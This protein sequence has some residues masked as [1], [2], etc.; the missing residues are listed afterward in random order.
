MTDIIQLSETVQLGDKT[1]TAVI[2]YNDKVLDQVAAIQAQSVAP[3][4]VWIIC[5]TEDEKAAI[6]EPPKNAEIWVGD[7]RRI[8]PQSDYLWIV[9]KAV[10]P[11]NRYLELVLKLSLTTT[12]RDVLLGSH[13][14][15]LKDGSC[16]PINKHQPVDVTHHTWFLRREWLPALNEKNSNIPLGYWISSNLKA[17]AGIRSMVLPE[18]ENADYI[19]QGPKNAC[20]DVEEYLAKA[21]TTSYKTDVVIQKPVEDKE[22]QAVMLL[23]DEEQI[24]T[25]WLQLA[26]EMHKRG[27]NNAIV[28]IATTGRGGLDATDIVT[29]LTNHDAKCGSSLPKHQVHNLQ[30]AG[31]SQLA[32]RVTRLLMAADVKVLIH[33]QQYGLDALQ[34]V[35]HLLP[36]MAI[37]G[38]PQRDLS[39]VMWMAELPINVLQR[40]HDFTVKLVLTTESDDSQPFERLLHSVQNAGY[41]GDQV[42]L[43]IFMECTSNV[44]TQRSAEK[45]FW[46]HGFKDLRHRIVPTNRAS[47]FVEAWYPSSDHEYAVILDDGIEVS[48]L[49]YVWVKYSILKYRYNPSPQRNLYGISLYTPRMVDTGEMREL[50]EPPSGFTPYLMQAPC[51]MGGGA[52]YFPEHWREFHDYMTARVADQTLHK[53]QTIEV[54]GARSRQWM[55][56]WRRYLDELVY[57]RGNVMLYPNFEDNASFST[58]HQL[59]EHDTKHA[60][61]NLDLPGAA[62]VVASL[63]NVPLLDTFS[64]ADRQ[65][66]DWDGLPVLDLWGRPATLE[67]LAERGQALQQ[68]VSACTESTAHDYDPA[69]LLCPFAVVKAA[70]DHKKKKK[71]PT[72][73]VT[74]YLPA[75]ATRSP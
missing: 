28:H 44:K 66:P 70:E 64:L 62:S 43:S 68:Q 55:H 67:T 48:P 9:D 20:A 59:P 49:F 38:L 45:L 25:A 10:I 12:Y 52:V 19:V 71:L 35:K 31:P 32:S 2:L 61:D 1:V 26:C 5:A 29:A 4:F 3:S 7:V 41:L 53:L 21:S 30:I 17:N 23:V 36:N 54:P 8:R 69:D 13:G 50:F 37:I 14:D 46:P 39:H 22:K 33:V 56:S 40:W 75:E 58:R 15:S 72:K 42:E 47:M 24:D 34:T 18:D 57:L 63:Y 73:V 27:D 16:E 11:G 6:V 74:L 60:A 65:L 51:S